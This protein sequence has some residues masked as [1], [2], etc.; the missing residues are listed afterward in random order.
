MNT[1]RLWTA[2]LLGASLIA[3]A[4]KT[5]EP[6]APRREEAPPPRTSAT[7]R[8]AEP[9]AAETRLPL[10]ACV[11]ESPSKQYCVRKMESNAGPCRGHGCI[12][13]VYQVYKTPDQMVF[14][15]DA[16]H[17]GQPIYLTDQG[18]LVT[19]TNHA[20]VG[21]RALLLLLHEAGGKSTPVTAGDLLAPSRFGSEKPFPTEVRGRELHVVLGEGQSVAFDF[22]GLKVKA[23][24]VHCQ[25]M[26]K[27]WVVVARSV[28]RATGTTAVAR[29]TCDKHAEAWSLQ[30]PEAAMAV[31]RDGKRLVT[32]NPDP[33]RSRSAHLATVWQQQGKTAVALR[34]LRLR[35]LTTVTERLP[36]ETCQGAICRSAP[37]LTF[38]VG[39]LL[40]LT[41][42]SGKEKKV[43][44]T[45]PALLKV[46]R[47]PWAFGPTPMPKAGGA[48]P[49]MGDPRA[50]ATLTVYGGLQCPYTAALMQ[51]LRDLLGVQPKGVKVVFMDYPLPFHKEAVP[52]ALA[53][54]S[55]LAQK[56]AA[57]FFA[58]LDLAFA[59]QTELT[60]ANVAAWAKAVGADPEKVRRD[61]EA[62][63]YKAD[64]D[65]GKTQGTQLG[66]R[67]TPTLYLNGVQVGH[68]EGFWKIRAALQPLL[69]KA[70]RPVK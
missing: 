8:A 10:P 61:V 2:L 45:S 26:G 28:F 7:P 43:D 58:F 35:D 53:A 15:V 4:R 23:P 40:T 47:D 6:A 59:H 52:A 67:G 22:D 5:P 29:G 18:V 66:V 68:A 50:K 3:C 16:V 62:E 21:P 36:L 41:L 48:T 49:W 33:F 54:R 25:A 63:T 42:P 24:D 44:L 39:G 37:S 11:L 55:V 1:M 14:E 13:W 32:R 20:V 70:L 69:G 57:A 9:R 17:D 31:T 65:A 46:Q 27:D 12:R 56:G 60:D 64:I 34:A 30:T 38:A 19:K 51:T